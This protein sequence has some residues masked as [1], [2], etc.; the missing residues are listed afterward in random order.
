MKKLYLFISLL[1]ICFIGFSQVSCR[2]DSS[3]L[4]DNLIS[5]ECEYV[6]VPDSFV[7]PINYSLKI[8]DKFFYSDQ[9]IRVKV[10]FRSSE[11]LGENVAGG[12]KPAE[13]IINYSDNLLQNTYYPIALAEKV[14][15]ENINGQ[16]ADIIYIINS[17]LDYYLGY[18]GDTSYH[19]VDFITLTLHE[20]LHGLGFYS[21]ISHQ[22]T[23]AFF[24][25]N[26]PTIF[27]RYVIDGQDNF[28]YQNDDSLYLSVTS[29][30]LYFKSQYSL[31][32]N[33]NTYPKIYAPNDYDEGGTFAHLDNE[34]FP[35]YNQNSLMSPFKNRNESIHDIG[36][37]TLGI[38]A[39]IGWADYFMQVQPSSDVQSYID[40]VTVVAHID[41]SLDVL[42]TYVVY[43]LD[44][45][46][47]SD[48]LLVLFDSIDNMF[49]A[50]IP[51]AYPAFDHNVLYYVSSRDRYGNIITSKISDSLPYYNNFHV[52]TDTVAPLIEHTPY[53]FFHEDSIYFN[54]TASITD[55]IGV[56]EAFVVVS[57]LDSLN[58]NDTLPMNNVFDDVYETLITFDDDF[59]NIIDTIAYKIVVK[60]VAYVQNI[61]FA[62]SDDFYIVP[63]FRKS[64]ILYSYMQ[65]FEADVSDFELRG[66]FIGLESGF[67]N[68]A[69]HSE[70]PYIVSGQD[71]VY[72]QYTAT[73]TKPLVINSTEAFLEFDE[74]VLVE[75]GEY[76]T[77][78]GQFGF[79]DYVIVEG[80][81][82]KQTWHAFEMNGYDSRVY[83]GWLNQ[84]YSSLSSDYSSLSEGSDNLFR[85]NKINLLMN[86]FIRPG[87]LVYI[88]FRLQSDA[89]KY[90]WGWCIDNIEIQKN[91]STGMN[92]INDAFFVYPNPVDEKL[93][94]SGIHGESIKC[95]NIYDCLGRI[96]ECSMLNPISVTNLDNGLYVIV[97]ET[98]RAVYS[99]KFKK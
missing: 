48:S 42:D 50:A 69:L 24:E 71:N 74:V 46:R 86:K 64:S 56:G 63:I 66:F 4:N 39:Q 17:D 43:S 83:D 72:V 79:W 70:H 78:F 37:V 9:M 95:I 26:Y 32:A 81:I 96:V 33:L 98:S 18:D 5:F 15:N 92:E 21:S 3:Q 25:G 30:E 6:N 27:D 2:F 40:S 90:A 28:V 7:N 34:L 75:P 52:G 38:M 57:Y 76:G 53:T 65:D 99:S 87:D 47:N 97:V 60:D 12:A 73:I 77:T 68:N 11:E 10:Y 1:I 51:P 94:V 80:S 62:P 88:R 55:N 85:H 58:S 36:D 8:L 31:A 67:E 22:D 19:K 13:N 16:S 54:I 20:M 44:N 14:L 45:F 89:K 91:V 61:Q 82:D 41:T 23:L 29:N 35:H 93:F 84:Y 59:L 49:S